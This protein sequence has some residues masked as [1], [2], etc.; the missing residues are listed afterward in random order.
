M[1]NALFEVMYQLHKQ[2]WINI[3]LPKQATLIEQSENDFWARNMIWARYFL[4]KGDYEKVY[5]YAMNFWEIEGMN[6]F[7]GKCRICL[8]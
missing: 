3:Y 6:L 7:S 2:D 4:M 1:M 5:N 8:V